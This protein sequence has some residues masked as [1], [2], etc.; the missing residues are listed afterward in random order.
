MCTTLCENTRKIH[1]WFFCC[2]NPMRSKVV[3]MSTSIEIITNQIGKKKLC[4]FLHFSKENI[5]KGRYRRKIGHFIL[6]VFSIRVINGWGHDECLEK[7]SL[8]F[9]RCTKGILC[10]WGAQRGWE[11]LENDL[12]MTWIPKELYQIDSH[13]RQIRGDHFSIH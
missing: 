2:K 1:P 5:M 8:I 12:M 9:F 13:A 7:P 11:R 4:P 3:L 10:C 6:N